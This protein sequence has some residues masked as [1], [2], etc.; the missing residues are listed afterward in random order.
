LADERTFIL[1]LEHDL[2]LTTIATE[3][4]GGEGGDGKG[5]KRLGLAAVVLE[6]AKLWRVT[7]R[8]RQLESR[9]EFQSQVSVPIRQDPQHNTYRFIM[10]PQ[11]Y[12][13]RKSNIQP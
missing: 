10:K 9:A 12:N 6:P 1:G 5:E 2:E 3:T 7:E 4:Q 8:L 11:H 13:C